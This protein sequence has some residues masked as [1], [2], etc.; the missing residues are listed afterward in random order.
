MKLLFFIWSFISQDTTI[1]LDASRSTDIDGDKISFVWSQTSGPKVTILNPTSVKATVNVGVGNYT[2][3]CIGTDSRGA[4]ASK[5]LH[6]FITIKSPTLPITFTSFSVTSSGQINTLNWTTGAE[7]TDIIM[8]P[9]K[10]LNNGK[11]WINIFTLVPTGT[12]KYAYSDDG[13]KAAQ[14][15]YRVSGLYTDG[16]SV[17]TKEIIVKYTAPPPPPPV[18]KCHKFLWW[19]WCDK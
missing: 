6:A 10:S 13:Q 11:T 12:K 1:I 3:H 18:K 8:I 9:Q 15:N 16:K 5:D 17:Y 7:S 2:F 14:I 19:T 4:S